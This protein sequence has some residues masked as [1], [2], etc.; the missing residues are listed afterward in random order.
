MASVE[1]RDEFNSYRT[2][3]KFFH[4]SPLRPQFG[5]WATDFR[6]P[7]SRPQSNSKVTEKILKICEQASEKLKKISQSSVRNHIKMRKFR[8]FFLALLSCSPFLGAN[9]TTIHIC[10][11]FELFI[12]WIVLPL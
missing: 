4:L 11:L 2:S 7:G 6:I 5:V 10:C 9:N 1:S 12:A 8:R 3:V